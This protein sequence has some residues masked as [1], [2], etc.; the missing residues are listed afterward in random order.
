M[1]EES[2]S[3][4]ALKKNLPIE[5]KFPKPSDVRLD[6]ETEESFKTAQDNLKKLILDS[7]EA[8]GTLIELAKEA[9]HPRTYEVLANFLKTAAELNHD[10]LTLQRDRKKLLGMDAPKGKGGDIKA[11]NL[12]FVGDNATLQRMIKDQMSNPAK[13]EDDDD[14]E[15]EIVDV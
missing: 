11:K 5:V 14:D 9:E 3:L 8:I 7:Q 4:T 12:V 2:K 10:L 13:I 15:D 6:A 1:E